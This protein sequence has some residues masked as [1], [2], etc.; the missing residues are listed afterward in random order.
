M[1]NTILKTITVRLGHTV[2]LLMNSWTSLFNGVKKCGLI[3]WDKYNIPAEQVTFHAHLSDGQ[4]PGQVIC[5]LNCK[6]KV[7]SDKH[8]TAL[9]KQNLKAACLKGKAGIQVL[10]AP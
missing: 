4:E 1:Q 2:V 8:A 6:K 9:D 7:N 10:C 3:V 5:S